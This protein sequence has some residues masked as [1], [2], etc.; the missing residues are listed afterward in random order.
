MIEFLREFFQVYLM[1]CQ[2]LWLTLAIGFLIS[3][4]FFKFI[5]TD[6]VEK[7]LGERGL[8]PIFISSIVGTL[9]PICCIGSLP[10]AITLRRKGATLGAVLAFMVA[11]PATSVSALVVCWKL[12]GL[13]FTVIIFFAIIVMAIIMGVVANGIKLK[14]GE[15]EHVHENGSCCHPEEH[16]EEAS[17][18]AVG[19]KIKGAVT[20][21]FVTLPK[22]MGVEILIG[23]A[24]ASFIT[25]FEPLQHL[26][27]DY[28]TGLTGYFFIL[29]VGLITYVCSTAS[30]PMADAFLQ[31]GLSHGQALC[32]LLVGPITSY[33]AIL[34]IKKDFGR[35]V[36]IIYLSI[37]C[38]L[39]LV[40]GLLY[41]AFILTG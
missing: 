10:I 34:V 39:S 32:Y 37:I 24:V 18:S 13:T 15:G 38:V 8:K 16:Y 20:Y 19:E 6:I 5:P 35:R 22:E 7:H 25:V 23:I 3:G 21:A 1:Y 30:V 9:L 17:K 36:L 28:L 4:L 12:L 29:I 27:R 33:S 40:Y 31:S 11:T 14:A 26:I 41:D 2:E